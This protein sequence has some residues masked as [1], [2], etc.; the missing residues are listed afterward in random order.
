[1]RVP[2]LHQPIAPFALMKR[3]PAAA[4]ATF[5]V[6]VIWLSAPRPAAAQTWPMFQGNPAHTGYLPMS[7]QPGQFN[8]RWT[9]NLGAI[10]GGPVPVNPVAAGDGRV[11]ATLRIFHDD[12]TQLFALRTSDGATLWTRKFENEPKVNPPSYV[13]GRV[14]VQTGNHSSDSWLWAL[15]GFSGTTI[16][17]S[18]VSE[19]WPRH[20]APT[21]YNGKVYVNGGYFGGMYGFNGSNGEQ[22]WF[23]EL[24]QDDEWTPAVDATRAYA[25]LGGGAPGLY[26]KKLVDGT[27]WTYGFIPDPDF[28]SRIWDMSLAPVIGA[29]GILAIHDG[30]LISFNPSAGTIGWQLQ[31]NF[32]GQPSVAGGRIYAVNNGGL[33]VYDEA[34][35]SLLW[36]W[37]P[38]SGAITQ[39]M[40]VTDTHVLASTRDAVYAIDRTTH[41][42]LW[43]FAA[44]DGYGQLAIADGK[45]LV[46]TYDGKLTAISLS[47]S[48]KPTS[49]SPNTGPSIGGTPVTITGTGFQAGAVVRLGGIPATITS[50]T[51]TSISAVAGP[52]VDGAVDVEVE[53]PDG[54]VGRLFDAY[55][56]VCGGAVP[57]AAVS[58]G[59]TV[60]AGQGATLSVALTG[61]GPWSLVWSDGVTQS[62]LASSPATRVVT[63]LSTTTYTILAVAD[64]ICAGAATGSAAV[65]VT[66]TPSATLT[67]PT[68]VCAGRTTTASVP[69]MPGATYV[70]TVTNG[71][72]LSGQGT[73]VLSFVG[74]SDPV[75]VA[76]DATH[77]TC[78]ASDSRTVPFAFSPS[79]SVSGGGTICAGG[80]TDISFNLTGTAPLSITWSDGFIQSVA[81]AGPGTRTVSP[82]A[83]RTY[84]IAA[85]HDGASCP[86]GSGTGSATVTVNPLPTVTIA[87]P[88]SFCAGAAGLTAS[89]P[90]AGAGAT[91]AWTISGGTFG[92]STTAPVVSFTPTGPSVTLGVTVGLPT[93]CS[94]S[95]SR[96]VSLAPP[97]SAVVSGGGTICSGNEGTIQVALSGTPPYSLTWSD[98]IVQS[99]IGS[100]P[101]QR[102][103]RPTATTTYS[104]TNVQDAS[105]SGAASGS[106]AFTVVASPSAVMTSSN[107]TICPGGSATL[108]VRLGGQGPYTLT[109]SDGFVET[110]TGPER[111]RTVSPAATRKYTIG[112]VRN[113]TCSVPGAGSTV[114]TVFP[115]PSASIVTVPSEVCADAEGLVASVPDSGAGTNYTWSITNGTI[116][117]GQGTR[118]IAWTAG[119]SGTAVVAVAIRVAAGCQVSGSASVPVNTRPAIPVITAPAS[120]ESGARGVAAEVVGGP[121]PG[122][123][124]TILNGTITSGAG[125]SRITFDTG[126]PGLVVLDVV[127]TN[128][129]GCHSPAGHLEIPVKGLTASRLAP[130]VLDVAGPGGQRYTTELVLS[131]PSPSP[132]RVDVL[133]TAASS[134]NAAGSG[135]AFETLA[136]GRQR[137]IPDVLA[138]LRGKGL[139]IP[140][141]GSPQ[142]GALRVTFD[143]VAAGWTPSASTRTTIPSGAGRAGLSIPTV[144]PEAANASK[145]WLFG[146]R[147]TAAD[148]S[149]VALVNAG[150]EGNIDL[151]VSLFSGEG[152]SVPRHVLPTVRLAAGQWL[153]LNTVLR[154]AGFASGYALVER[155][156]GTAPF[157]AYAVFNDNATND[158]SVVA[159]TPVNRLPAPQL[160]PVVVETGAFTSELVL[161][162]PG[163]VAIKARLWFTESLA[164]PGGYS[165]GGVTVDLAPGEQKILPG[166]LAELRRRGLEIVPA[167][168]DY[169]GTLAVTFS[170]GGEAADGWAGARTATAGAG[171]GRYGLFCA[172]Q[173]PKASTSDVWLFGLLQHA[174]ARTNLA[175]VNAAANL[176]TVTLRYAVYDGVTGMKVGTSEPVTLGP[177][178]WMQLNGVLAR[179]KVENGYIRVERVDGTAPFLAYAVVND[180]GIPGKGTGDGSFVEMSTNT[181]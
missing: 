64:T 73:N 145:V 86:A 82:T 120:L 46:A 84:T 97:P 155:I 124:W 51:A 33:S 15:D 24:P 52:H 139:A 10:P 112:S 174:D 104:V 43:T 134:L 133:Y 144:E 93:T 146:L 167:N 122:W 115:D 141:D 117:S 28:E 71:T 100:S 92:G 56:Y 123:S 57:T 175:L 131:N 149:N 58:G 59:D 81:A 40:I 165:M 171:A 99:G 50:L 126:D 180:G 35:H 21:V 136:A 161:A 5:F 14:Y 1:M 20:Y 61:T 54:D 42:S 148:R 157:H 173:S 76:V 31:E 23:T 176:G 27:A 107:A 75:T 154:T 79:G 30:R 22:L 98:G 18:P 142:G 151:K 96:V 39:P 34:S 153:Q 11:Y 29:H 32:T 80:S 178:A 147:E 69:P 152:A 94:A 78:G 105:C 55:T 47:S 83:T 125:T 163:A 110:V 74:T 109:W 108:T 87:A 41:E 67:V 45:L 95:S 156:A 13:N 118:S 25:Y 72:I 70:W 137:I 9:K 12:V 44:P 91:Y 2:T 4:V 164:N 89:V 68:R 135:S 166:I 77:G 7:L 168:R 113:A 63:P 17:Q 53:N 160:V 60:C 140:S 170:A 103:V 181:P 6:L 90:D 88:A 101:A 3:F 36:S 128:A 116:E 138:W 172:A 37:T 127:E 143:G 38:P 159:A 130:I 132:V 19:Q 65:T 66:P 62:G 16:F 111:T 102:T 85:L 129:K 49:I 150:V 48:A 8:V 169:A 158:G 179:W 26:I 177:G 162:N 121:G 114:V 106:A 119:S